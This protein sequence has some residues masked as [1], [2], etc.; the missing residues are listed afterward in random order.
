L[1]GTVCNTVTVISVIR[2]PQACLASGAPCCQSPVSAICRRDALYRPS[3]L[4]QAGDV[5]GRQPRAPPCRTYC[6]TARQIFHKTCAGSKGW[7]ETAEASKS[8]QSHAAPSSAQSRGQHSSTSLKDTAVEKPAGG[9]SRNPVRFSPVTA[10]LTS[11]ERKQLDWL[12]RKQQQG[13][14]TPG[15]V[16]SAESDTAFATTATPRPPS[17]PA[18]PPILP[19]RSNNQVPLGHP[20]GQTRR[21]NQCVQYA[22][23]QARSRQLLH[24]TP[25]PAAVLVAGPPSWERRHLP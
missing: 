21:G 16:Q 13:L 19:S 7:D 22:T 3:H 20:H 12:Q 4:Q 25:P 8:F 17:L 24:H 10:F 9:R 2:N 5:V 14:D 23:L 1:H 15:S 11:K 6:P 18:P